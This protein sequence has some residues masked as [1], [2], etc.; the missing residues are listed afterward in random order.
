MK[1][2]I[3]TK[4]ENFAKHNDLSKAL[5]ELGHSVTYDWTGHGPVFGSGVE[6][7][8]EV[9]QLETNG[10]TDADAVIVLWPGGRGTH[11]EMG[12]AIGTGKPVLFYSDVPEHH[13]AFAETCAFYWHPLVTRCQSITELMDAIALVQESQ[14]TVATNFS[15]RSNAECIETM[16]QLEPAINNGTAKKL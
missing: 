7:I 6:R 3:A 12:I 4:L 9:A 11:V 13:G 5:Q 15:G 14:V 10:V 1:F 16:K 2:Y 8:M